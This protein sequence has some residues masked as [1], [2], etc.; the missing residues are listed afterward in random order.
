[1]NGV[2]K[3]FV[4]YAGYKHAEDVVSKGAR[5]GDSVCV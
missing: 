1:M 3:V 5:T 2:A 4:D